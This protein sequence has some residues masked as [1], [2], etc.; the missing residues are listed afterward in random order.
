M[1]VSNQLP[2]P[3]LPVTPVRALDPAKLPA[4]QAIE[5]RS[6]GQ[7]T[8][9]QTLVAIGRQVL[10]LDLPER[11]PAGTTLTLQAQGEG[12]NRQFVLLQS[13]AG[14]PIPLPAAARLLLQNLLAT[15]AGKV[16][17]GQVLA[18]NGDGTSSVALGKQLIDLPLPRNLPAGSLVRFQ[19]TQSGTELRLLPAQPANQP[20]STTLS[21]AVSP[22]SQPAFERL[23]LQPGQRVQAQ[24][25]ANLASGET[26]IAIDG[27]KFV[28]TL[29]QTRAPGTNL[30]LQAES[31]GANLR[32]VLLQPAAQPR[33]Q[34]LTPL[35]A[36]LAAVGDAARAD[37]DSLAP[38]LSTLNR[39]IAKSPELP[40]AVA[41]AAQ[42]LLA[43]QLPLDGDLSGDDLRQAISRSG[44]FTDPA[45]ARTDIKSALLQLRSAILVWLG[46][47]A[48]RLP[49]PG[50]RGA[51]PPP[52][53]G[54]QPRSQPAMPLQSN[55]GASASDLARALLGEANSALSRIRLF[56][57]A[58]LPEPAPGH[59]EKPT[60]VLVE[61]PVRLGQEQALAQFQV[62]RDGGDGEGTKAARRGWQLRFSVNFSAIGEVGARIGLLG[63]KVNISIWAERAATA[64]ALDS[65]LPEVTRALAAKGI[66]TVSL[67]C[68]Q[69]IPKAARPLPAGLYV[70][71]TG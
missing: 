6:L 35:Q 48:L 27:Q 71:A 61:L 20:A 8:N 65:M 16:L 17:A 15:N 59:T 44:V 57:L 40:P 36:L 54:S 58:A 32:L 21:I 25:V 49:P 69:G 66:E 13:E 12:A 39:L 30:P 62:G 56:Q 51:S 23:G 60:Q 52:V 1:P 3:T 38:A 42:V 47:E 45:L 26:E 11:P 18:N 24:V 19:V 2:L 31:D 28:V 37:Q 68:Q 41:K 29:P 53:R 22:R 4:G 55:E 70:D 14:E 64:Q 10:S 5:G 33:P 43:S 67:K 50:K 7:G 9:G 46:P 63:H 34:A